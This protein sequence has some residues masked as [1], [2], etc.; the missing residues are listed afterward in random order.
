MDLAGQ[1]L[2]IAEAEGIDL[3]GV[4]DLAPAREPMARFGR[5]DAARYPRA[6]SIGLRIPDSIV[7]GLADR[8]GRHASVAYRTHGRETLNLRLDL[9]AS[10]MASLLQREG[11]AALPIP[12][13]R[14]TDDATL[15]AAFSHKMAA[16]LAGLGWIGKSCLLVTPQFGPRVRWATVLTDAPLQPTGRM[17][18]E[19]C[20]ECARCAEACPAKAI[21]GRA[22]IPGE[23]REARC[24]ARAC[25]AYLDEMETAD[26]AVCG[27]CVYACPHGRRPPR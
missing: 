12:A 27:M 15:S 9:A 11:F 24:D 22:F 26:G 10:R 18:D 23:E 19:R 14:R 25:G 17:M 7:E 5:L 21:H 16:S 4:A 13:S 2:M 3:I 8:G 1:L 20:G 6:I